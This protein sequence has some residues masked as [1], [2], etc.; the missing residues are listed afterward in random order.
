MKYLVFLLFFVAAVFGFIYPITV[1]LVGSDGRTVAADSAFCTVLA[2]SETLLTPTRMSSV[3]RSTTIDFDFPETLW[4]AT[5]I[6]SAF[7]E[8]TLFDTV[9]FTIP[10]ATNPFMLTSMLSNTLSEAHG[11]GL[12]QSKAILPFLLTMEENEIV[13]TLSGSSSRPI[14]VI[15][16]D[17]KCVD[18]YL[19]DSSGEAIDITGASAVFTVKQRASDITAYI[20]DTLELIEPA[21]GFLRLDLN[22]LQ[23]SIVPQSYSADIQLSFPDSSIATVWQNRFIVQW[24]VTR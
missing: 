22:P 18:I 7:W 6:I 10:S 23:T 11:S 1:D 8:D 2:N 9:A 14:S 13:A 17:S 4:F 16:G 3:A 12:W 15:R 21:E 5:A 20:V 24:D 19:V